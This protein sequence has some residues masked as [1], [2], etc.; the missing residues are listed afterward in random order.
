MN[1]MKITWLRVQA[2][3]PPILKRTSACAVA[4]QAA[5][6]SPTPQRFHVSAPIDIAALDRELDALGLQDPLLALDCLLSDSP[7]YRAIEMQEGVC[8]HAVGDASH[9]ALARVIS[10]HK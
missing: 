5:E 9:Q 10:Q 6:R 4:A 7:K 2:I 8:G 3:L 1:M